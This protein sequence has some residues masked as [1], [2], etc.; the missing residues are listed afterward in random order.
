MMGVGVG[1]WETR[2]CYHYRC[3]SPSKGKKRGLRALTPPRHKLP[4]LLPGIRIAAASHVH[5]E[6]QKEAG[7]SP[8]YL[9]LPALVV[10]VGPTPSAPLTADDGG[11]GAELEDGGR[12]LERERD[13]GEGVRRIMW[14]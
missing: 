12:D 11:G 7:K 5:G 10:L 4:I 3:S 1:C 8:K 9:F 14:A 13:A 6:H 2:L